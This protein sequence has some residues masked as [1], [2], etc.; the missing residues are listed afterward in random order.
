MNPTPT[1]TPTTPVVSPVL[2][3]LRSR[4]A[5]AA[6]IGTLVNLLIVFLPPDVAPRIEDMRDELVLAVTVLV[7]LVI[8]GISYEDANKPAPGTTTSTVE[9]SAQTVSSTPPAGSTPSTPHG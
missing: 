8:G 5:L 7:G 2:A 4:K 1:P 9:V 6:I 3:L